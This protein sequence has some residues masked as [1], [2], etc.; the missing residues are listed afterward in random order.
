VLQF[1]LES[2]AWLGRAQG[3]HTAPPPPATYNSSSSRCQQTRADSGAELSWWVGCRVT[4]R[5]P[6]T[7]GAQ[8]QQ[9][10]QVLANTC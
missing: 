4:I 3:H 7:C 2:L 5:L 6:T 1:A 9:K 10:M 8:Q